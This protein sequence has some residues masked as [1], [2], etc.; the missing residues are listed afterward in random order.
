MTVRAFRYRDLDRWSREEA[1]LWNWFHSSFPA[2][3]NWEIWLREVLM[4][5]LATPSGRRATLV[6]SNTVK[7]TEEPQTYLIEKDETV[8]GRDDECDVVLPEKVITKQHARI[9]RDDEGCRLEDLGSSMGTFRRNK[10]LE[11]GDPVTL[12]T[13]DQFSI[14]PYS[15][16]FQVEAVWSKTL[17]FKLGRTLL[18]TATAGEFDDH[19]R[20]DAV[21]LPIMLSPLEAPLRVDLETGL[22]GEIVS[23]LAPSLGEHLDAEGLTEVD[24]ALAEFALLALWDRANQDL[25]WDLR[26]SLG[27]LKSAV[28]L[29]RDERGIVVSASLQ[30]RE[31]PRSV[32]LFLPF[33]TLERM[34]YNPSIQS[35][36]A[37]LQ[38]VGWDCPI[39][40]ATEKFLPKDLAE[41]DPGDVLLVGRRAALWYPDGF[42]RGR[43]LISQGSNFSSF[44][45][46]NYFETESELPDPQETMPTDADAQNASNFDDLPVK[47]H[48]VI[49]EKRL[50]LGE[51]ESLT[52]GAVIEFDRAIDTAA[53][54]IVNGAKIGRGEL[55]E[56]EGK[57]GVRVTEWVRR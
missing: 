48:V 11:Q 12:S 2:A 19:R 32:R 31:T 22:L 23:G 33:R 10:K 9:L 29:D 36:G 57:L 4:E 8:L 46:D 50:T 51:L 24:W 56:I 44:Q 34:R 28:P 15:F 49:G 1:A 27:P 26:F 35:R 7:P 45:A 37:S 14:F 54:L 17:S 16:R 21:E 39:S 41:I 20:R 18:R 30:I 42:R 47:L 55:V 43:R 40:I 3:E 5:T 6:V 38:A 25:A 52:A 13:S 53:D